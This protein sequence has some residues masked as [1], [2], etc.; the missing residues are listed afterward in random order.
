MIDVNPYTSLIAAITQKKINKMLTE[1]AS[2]NAISLE[3]L[4]QLPN[5]SI[6]FKLGSSE[7]DMQKYRQNLLEMNQK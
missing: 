4:N 1:F 3:E 6:Y 2:K 7:E 5:M